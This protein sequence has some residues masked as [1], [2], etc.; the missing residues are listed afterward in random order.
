MKGLSGWFYGGAGVSSPLWLHSLTVGWQVAVS[1][2]GGIVLALTIYNKILE[3]KQRRR[4]L[5]LPEER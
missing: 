5:A 1:L 3:L 4:N 2:M